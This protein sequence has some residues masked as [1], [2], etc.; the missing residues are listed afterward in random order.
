MKY[1]RYKLVDFLNEEVRDDADQKQFVGGDSNKGKKSGKPDAKET[2]GDY[3]LKQVANV[4]AAAVKSHTDAK[5]KLDAKNLKASGKLK[6]KAGK[7]VSVAGQAEI[8]IKT[9]KADF[10]VPIKI[11]DKEVN[12]NIQGLN[13]ANPKDLHGKDIKGSFIDPTTNKEITVG[14]NI[15]PESDKY[16]F[17]AGETKDNTSFDVSLNINKSH[18][19]AG[20]NVGFDTNDFIPSKFAPKVNVGVEYDNTGGF[21][22]NVTAQKDFKTRKGTVGVS[23][24]ARASGEEKYGGVGLTYTPDKK[25]KKT[26][27]DTVSKIA[28]KGMKKAK[29]Y[30]E[31]GDET[32][33]GKLKAVKDKEGNVVKDKEGKTVTKAQKKVDTIKKD[34]ESAAEKIRENKVLMS[35]SELEMFIESMIKF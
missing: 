2:Q 23:A 32:K 19:T 9:G 27:Q 34:V 28:T 16:S 1:Y 20:G 24:Q 17:T 22:G 10:S 25:D 5:A 3:N 29:D 6:V 21:S 35:R 12:L 13:V 31:F 8:D 30:V 11:K 18:F 33:A 4:V 14:I 26:P 7:N 15:D